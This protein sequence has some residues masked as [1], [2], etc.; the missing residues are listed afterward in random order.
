MLHL[1]VALWEGVIQCPRWGWR[2]IGCLVEGVAP[3]SGRQATVQLNG[4]IDACGVPLKAQVLHREIHGHARDCS[5]MHSQL[6]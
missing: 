2:V 3:A 5:P 1:C 4:Y 6:L